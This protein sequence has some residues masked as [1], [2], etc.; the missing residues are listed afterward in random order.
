MKKL[1]VLIFISLMLFASCSSGG[2]KPGGS[3]Q[4]SGSTV[5]SQPTDSS[6]GVTSGTQTDVPDTSSLKK[7]GDNLWEIPLPDYLSSKGHVYTATGMYT[8]GDYLLA[9]YC[10]T[11][12]T[13]DPSDDAVLLLFDIRTGKLIAETRRNRMARFSLLDN[14]YVSVIDDSTL[15]TTILDSSFKVTAEYAALGNDIMTSLAFVS[16]DMKYFVW[17]SEEARVTMKNLE[18]GTV[19]DLGMVA[20]DPAY[21]AEYN[22]T[23]Y[24]ISYSD[25]GQVNYALDMN[26]GTLAPLDEYNG[27]APVGYSLPAF[28]H[29][30]ISSVVMLPEKPGKLYLFEELDSA[31]TYLFDYRDGLFVSQAAGDG[32]EAGVNLYSVLHSRK[33]TVSVPSDPDNS[34]IGYMRLADYGEVFID[35]TVG[36]EYPRLFM[37][38][39][40]EMSEGESI[41]IT[42]T[43]RAGLLSRADGMKNN[44]ENNYGIKV[45]YGEEGSGFNAYDYSGAVVTDEIR[46]YNA[47]NILHNTLAK[48]P[49]GI[50]GEMLDEGLNGF[51]F[52]LCG[53]LSGTVPGSI[54]SALAITFTDWETS[55]KRIACDVGGYYMLDQTIAHELMHVMDDAIQNAENT[56]GIPYYSLWLGLL[57]EGV[58]YYYYYVDANG[59]EPSDISYTVMG[60]MSED[61][62]YFID[63]YS[64]TYPTEDRARIM[65]YLFKTD[66][67][68]LSPSIRGDHLIE[69]CRALCLILRKVF[70]SVAAEDGL[71]WESGLGPLDENEMYIFIEKYNKYLETHQAAG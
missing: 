36:Y 43:D 71:F 5:T 4:V 20:S 44:I 52:Y 61:N 18:T 50:F 28:V 26:A 46:I 67:G 17:F 39:P 63:A 60:E 21:C 7:V 64:K 1:L 37:W 53:K 16:C 49:R 69:K 24:L 47:M 59:N 6:S 68:T 70:P 13:V 25:N 11:P 56:T 10:D 12:N 54:S 35:V 48:Y 2:K 58:D 14:G 45:F 34:Y 41:G 31:Q 38:I 62:I 66:N 55:T 19:T 30:E 3:S 57:P 27:T 9:V 42:V 23:A 29:S 33:L 40:G 51:N 65:E 22:G 8:R 32:G 15:K